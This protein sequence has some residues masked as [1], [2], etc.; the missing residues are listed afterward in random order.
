MSDMRGWSHPTMIHPDV[1]LMLFR[2]VRNWSNPFI[3]HHS[4][5][6]IGLYA[7]T[8]HGTLSQFFLDACDQN[9]LSL[10]SHF[11][12]CPTVFKAIFKVIETIFI[13]SIDDWDEKLRLALDCSWTC[14]VFVKVFQLFM[15]PLKLLEEFE[16]FPYLLSVVRQENLSWIGKRH[17]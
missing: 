14:R 16:H 3:R 10:L 5:Y 4:Y 17:Y 8:H 12:D 13:A 2:I 9:V 6:C 11:S 7:F 1:I 15:C